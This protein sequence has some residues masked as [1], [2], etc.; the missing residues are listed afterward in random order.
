MESEIDLMMIKKREER[1]NSAL[2]E[3]TCD[4]SPISAGENAGYAL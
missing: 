1:M 3:L 2:L 4:A